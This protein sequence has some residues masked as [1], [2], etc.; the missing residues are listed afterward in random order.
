MQEYYEYDAVSG[1]IEAGIFG[2]DYFNGIEKIYRK[3]KYD[4]YYDPVAKR[5]RR[6][7]HNPEWATM[8]IVVVG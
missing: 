4:P 3:T 7:Y 5:R 2:F 1:T 8:P 6:G